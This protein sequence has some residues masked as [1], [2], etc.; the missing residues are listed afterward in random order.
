MRHDVGLRGGRG[1]AVVLCE[2]LRIW[3]EHGAQGGGVKGRASCHQI[4]EGCAGFKQSS[5]ALVLLREYV[6]IYQ[7]TKGTTGLGRM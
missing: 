4:L 2:S 1:R 5:I 6:P 7:T 3:R